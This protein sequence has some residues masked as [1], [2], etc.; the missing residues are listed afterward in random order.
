M[1]PPAASRCWAGVSLRMTS[2]SRRRTSFFFMGSP[3][4]FQRTPGA[5]SRHAEKGAAAN[6][7]VTAGLGVGARR[8]GGSRQDEGVGGFDRRGLF[9]IGGAGEEC[10]QPLAGRH[11]HGHR[12]PDERGVGGG[13]AQTAVLHGKGGGGQRQADEGALQGAKYPL[14]GGMEE[15]AATF[16]L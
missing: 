10:A 4:R 8:R 14:F 6:A 2:R 15:T 1:M 13:V 5:E 12:M 9:L 3:W 11:Q 16:A 7:G